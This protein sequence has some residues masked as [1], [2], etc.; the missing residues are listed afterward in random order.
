MFPVSPEP[1]SQSEQS[2]LPTLTQALPILPS[3]ENEQY[4]PAHSAASRDASSAVII[5]TPQAIAASPSSSSSTS[6]SASSA[7]SPKARRRNSPISPIGVTTPKT[8][9]KKKAPAS[10]SSGKEKAEK[11]VGRRRGP[12][13]PEQR[14]QA[15]EIRKLR[16]CLRC[17][18]LKKVC[19]KGDPCGGCQPAHARLW[20]VPCT[21]MDIKDIAS[22]LKG[23]NADYE[24]H[25]NCSV[26]IANIKGFSQYEHRFYITHGYGYFMPIKAHEVYVVDEKCF[27]VDWMEQ[28][29]P[30]NSQTKTFEV[31]TAK[32][33]ANLDTISAPMISNYLDMHIDQG[34]EKFVDEY[35]DGTKFVTE[36][37][38]TTYRYYVRT[39]LP[40]I[41]KGL[42]LVVAYALT[43][44][45][46]LIEGLPEQQRRESLIVDPQSRYYG[47]SCA[48]VM[49]NFQIKKA[50]ADMWR[51]LMKDIL[52]ELSALYSSVYSG[53]KLKNWPTIFMT[54][55]LILC[56]W[57][58][59]QFDCHYRVPDEGA[60]KNFCH[61][62]ESVPVGVIVGLFSAISTKLPSFLEWDT[63]KHSHVLNN[64]LAVCDAM[65]EIRG[66]VEKYETYLRGRNDAKYDREDFDCLSNKFL[67]KLVIRA[68]S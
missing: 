15:H 19:D 44:H 53:D 39:Q 33:A 54:A 16:A 46:T 56:V 14:Q 63:R 42:K 24:R 43:L 48:P 4:S 35:F 34:F 40:V 36:L 22:F 52:E 38:K 31:N 11:K 50:M 5:R 68:N 58:L 26:S 1:E 7:G 9:V 64:N 12:L 17:K 21:R 28:L 2:Q 67:S 27:G 57:E 45:I 18:F 51:E 60:V 62:M 8:I 61:D 10:A 6:P 59:M 25:V 30:S 49:I 32:L 65:T 47:K 55:A 37:L 13:R 3:P 66:H 41:R 29:G 23:W 20:Q